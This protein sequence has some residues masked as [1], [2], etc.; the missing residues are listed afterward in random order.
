MAGV[1]VT[2]SSPAG[3]KPTSEVL[4]MIENAAERNDLA[5][6]NAEEK[7]I[8]ELISQQDTRIIFA[9][10]K[11]EEISL[12]AEKEALRLRGLLSDIR[13]R[14]RALLKAAADPWASASH[15]RSKQDSEKKRRSV[16]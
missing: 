11:G 15:L 13:R 7:H 4:V 3:N 10:R 2:S 12:E 8:E 5:A 1:Y 14:K 9:L 6:L 16:R